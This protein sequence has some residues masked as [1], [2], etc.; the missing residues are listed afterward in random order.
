MARIVIEMVYTGD[1]FEGN[2]PAEVVRAMKESALFEKEIAD[3]KYKDRV[4]Q[5]T[6]MIYGESLDTA[7]ARR[8]LESLRQAELIRYIEEV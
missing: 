1:R 8:F 2:T 3:E 6:K 7:S 4:A 5:R